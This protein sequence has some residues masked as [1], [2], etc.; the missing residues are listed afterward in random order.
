MKLK[1]GILSVVFILASLFAIAQ[2]DSLTN[3]ENYKL[4][5]P[6]SKSIPNFSG[7]HQ[8]QTARL[9]SDKPIRIQVLNSRNEPAKDL[10]IILQKFLSPELRCG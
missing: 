7:D 3:S 10:A 5:K 6:V 9:K 2:N 8:T 4:I 1:T